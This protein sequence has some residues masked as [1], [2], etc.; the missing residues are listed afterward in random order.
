MLLHRRVT[1]SMI[2]TTHQSSEHIVISRSALSLDK[3]I[4]ATPNTLN[5]FS[6]QRSS[7]VSEF[8]FSKN[9]FLNRTPPPLIGASMR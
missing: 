9:Y 4:I 8:Y 1:R 6:K 5:T 7:S 3:D 2:V